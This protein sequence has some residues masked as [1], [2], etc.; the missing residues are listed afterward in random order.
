MKRAIF[1]LLSLR[2]VLG[3][4]DLILVFHVALVVDFEKH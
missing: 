1:K 3:F 4:T 2:D